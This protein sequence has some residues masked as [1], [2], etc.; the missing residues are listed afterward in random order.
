VVIVLIGRERLH[1]WVLYV[2]NLV[3]RRFG[4]KTPIVLPEGE[5]P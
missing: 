1:R 3:L 5:A 4:A 2:P